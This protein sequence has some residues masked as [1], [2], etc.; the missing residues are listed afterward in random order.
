MTTITLHDIKATQTKLAAMI[1]EFESASRTTTLLVF[2]EAEIA[3][4]AG[5]HYAGAIL[6][7]DGT[8]AHHVVLLP[9]DRESINWK[10]AIAWAAEVGGELPS[11]REQALLY[12]NLKGKFVE[13]WYW[14]AEQH[15]SNGEYAWFQN[16]GFGSQGITRKSDEGRARAVRRV[17]A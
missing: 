5:E 8:I 13:T 7:D 10:D 4:S 2:P 14:S 11:R 6:N 15:E 3:L 16:F 1:A 9:G 17:K 12:A